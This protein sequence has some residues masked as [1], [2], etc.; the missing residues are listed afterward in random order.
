MFFLKEPLVSKRLQTLIEQTQFV[1][2][3]QEEAKDVCSAAFSSLLNRIDG[4]L[5]SSNG[6]QAKRLKQVYDMLAGQAEQ[7]VT[8]TQG[9]IEFLQEQLKALTSITKLQDPKKAQELLDLLLDPEEELMPTP[10]FKQSVM[11]ELVA[12][13]ESFNAVIEDIAAALEEGDL[14]NVEAM[15]EQLALAAA[16]DDMDDEDEDED[17]CG[18]DEDG[19]GSGC[20]SGGCGDCKTGCGASDDKGI[21][22]FGSISAYDRELA[23]DK[24]NNASND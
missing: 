10:E 14:A 16:E 12:S 4:Q 13:Q 20:S 3:R 23:K 1:L 18:D 21:D 8:D 22:I 6:A 5:K 2:A 9:D 24:K 7:L 17:S 11:E 19:C 15:L